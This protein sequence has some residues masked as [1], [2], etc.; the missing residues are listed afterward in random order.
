MFECPGCERR[1]ELMQQFANM[2]DA[3]RRRREKLEERLKRTAARNSC[4]CLNRFL[5]E[6]YLESLV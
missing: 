2:A 1:Q 6:D 5:Q 4:E 3:E